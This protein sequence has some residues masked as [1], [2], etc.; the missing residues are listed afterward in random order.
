LRPNVEAW[1]ERGGDLEFRDRR[2]AFWKR[3]GDGPV[4]L[5]LHGFPSSSFDWRHLWDLTDGRAA[6]AFD[7][8]GF[9]LSDK[10][11]DHD[12]S[13]LW[14]ADLA[15]EVVSLHG[16]GRPVQLVAHD[17]GTTVANELMARDIEGKLGFELAG[18]ML[19]NGSMIQSAA[20]PILSQRVLRGRFGR[21]AAKL[22]SERF[23]KAQFGTIFSPSHPLTDEEAAD[24]WELIAHD[25][26]DRIGHLLIGY[27]DEREA[28]AE[29]WHGAIRDW[30]GHLQLGWAMKDPVAT[31][32]VLNAVQALRLAAP[33][34]EWPDL[35]HYPQIEEPETVLGTLE[36]ALSTPL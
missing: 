17:M 2:I 20:S 7:C 3:D 34:D 10:P 31:T 25:G 22:A 29:R 8:L 9:G 5:F 12:Y 26:G 23:F 19:F 28:R 36:K 30:Q 15:E 1:R 21:F 27:M 24:Q 18:V 4:L 33:L 32:A 6:L 14:Q 11:A 16:G 35:G 13:L